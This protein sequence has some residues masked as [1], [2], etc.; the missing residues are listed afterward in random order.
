MKTMTA[1]IAATAL[2]LGLVGSA[3]AE[4]YT[5]SGWLA[6][7]HP[8]T[9][10]QENWAKM[11]RDGTDGA[12]DITV[13]PGAA[14]VPP[15][16]TLQAVADGV[17]IG[18]HVAPLYHPSEMPVSFLAGQAGGYAENPDFFVLSAAYLDYAMHDPVASAEWRAQRALPILTISTPIYHFI[19]ASVIS[20]ADEMKGKKVRAP[21]GLW[22]S[23][24]E[25]Y[26]MISVN[27]PFNEVYTSMERGAVDCALTDMANLTSGATLIELAKSAIMILISPGYNAAQITL[28]LDFWKNATPEQR[29]LML[30]S[31]AK[32]MAGA[33]VEYN[34]EAKTATEAA[35]AKGM[36]IVEP[37]DEMKAIQQAFSGQW[38][39]TL[40]KDGTEKY[41]LSDPAAVL[42]AEDVYI[43]KWT[44]L[45]KDLDK[46]DAD[47]FAQILSDNLFSKVDENAYGI[48]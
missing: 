20:T 6:P 36:Q 27:L 13:I 42:A 1:T 30:D 41:G 43:G 25:A 3:S 14:I 29:R 19:C 28:N 21:G 37:T 34:N 10:G 12:I 46:T 47:A 38:Y 39:D 7:T 18:G 22:A 4:E 32:A 33:I 16:S 5:F 11:V 2:A 40:I 8:M 45:L 35:V 15:L 23:I 44:E 9:H 48:N 24:S 17:V 31:A 26:G